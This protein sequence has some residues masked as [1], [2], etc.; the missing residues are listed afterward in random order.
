MNLAGQAQRRPGRTRAPVGLL[1]DIA[2]DRADLE[3]DA[4][5]RAEGPFHPAQGFVGTHGLFGG[6]L[7]R[8]YA[9]LKAYR[10]DP[11]PRRKATLKAWFDR[12]FRRR[13]GFA[14][15]DRT[16]PRLAPHGLAGCRRWPHR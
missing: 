5:Q 8:L 12:L 10:D 1:D 7:G 2:L 11:A 6:E 16:A 3:V 9:D 13:T 14:L 4:L 15:L